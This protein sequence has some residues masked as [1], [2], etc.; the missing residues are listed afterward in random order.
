[1]QTNN[2]VSSSSIETFP[3]DHLQKYI[4]TL[5]F[6]STL[7]NIPEVLRPSEEDSFSKYCGERI[8]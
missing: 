5:N 4:H 8:K 3:D 6:I 1:M 2:A 7:P